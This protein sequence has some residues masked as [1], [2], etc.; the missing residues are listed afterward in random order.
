MTTY[1]FDW[2]DAFT[3][4]PFGGN[5]CAVFHDAADVDDATC[6]AI[7]RETSLSECTFLGPSSKADRSAPLK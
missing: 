4:R 3:V 6:M 5:G 2:V 7:V 1:Q